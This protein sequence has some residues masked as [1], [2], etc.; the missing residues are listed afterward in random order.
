LAAAVEYVLLQGASS[1]LEDDEDKGLL[2]RTRPLQRQEFDYVIIVC[3]VATTAMT[4][5]R[6][7]PP[8]TERSRGQTGGSNR[9]SAHVSAA[10]SS[11]SLEEPLAKDWVLLLDDEGSSSIKPLAKEPR[12]RQLFADT[13][14]E[15]DAVW[16]PVASAHVGA[17]QLCLHSPAQYLLQM[18]FMINAN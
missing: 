11:S 5:L 15:V 8:A 2:G 14:A 13:H 18:M 9:S 3:V 10:S 7:L 6:S 17:R 12:V 4:S 1:F 16:A